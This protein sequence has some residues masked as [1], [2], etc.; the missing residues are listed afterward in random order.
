MTKDAFIS[1]GRRESLGFVGR[2]YQSLKLRGYEIWF[3]KVNIPDGDDY[4]KRISHGI[5]SAHN[6][7]LILAPRCLTSP[8]CLIELEYARKLGKRVIPIDQNVIFDTKDAPLS[9]QERSALVQFYEANGMEVLPIFSK[10]DVLNRS[11]ELLGKTDWVH[12]RQQLSEDDINQLYNWQLTYENR[13][14]RHEELEFTKNTE[15]QIPIFGKDIDN[16]EE[17]FERILKV[18]ESQKEYIYLHTE[19]IQKAL[20]WEANRRQTNLL[21]VGKQRQKAQNWLTQNFVSPNQ[22]PCLP[23]VLHSEFITESKKNADNLMSEVFLCFAP[24]ENKETQ[25]IRKGL[26]KAGITVILPNNSIQRENQK[27]FDTSNYT[28]EIKEQIAHADNFVFVLSNSSAKNSDCLR[29][30]RFALTFHKRIIVVLAKEVN[31]KELPEALRSLS[32]Y[33]DLTDNRTED[34]FTN[35]LD[36]EKDLSELICIIEDNY[37]YY[38]NHKRYLAQ[39]LKWKEQHQNDA[40][41]LRGHNLEKAQTWLHQGQ[42][43]RNSANSTKLNTPTKLHKKFIEESITKIGTLSSEVFISYSRTDGDFARW[44]NEELQLNGR[45]TWFDQECIP[46]GSDFGL[47]IKNGIETSDNFLFILSPASISS[48]YCK[49]EVLHALSMGKR[50]ILVRFQAVEKMP[51]YFPSHIQWIDFSKND[52]QADNGQQ[53]RELLRTLNTDREHTQKHSK[54]QQ[55][56]L[57]WNT[58]EKNYA[59]LLIGNELAIAENWLEE[60]QKHNKIPTSTSIQKDFI[61]ESIKS[62]NTQKRKQEKTILRLRVFLTLAVIALLAACGLGLWVHSLNMQN[63]IQFLELKVAQDSL[64]Q[65]TEKEKALKFQ[66]YFQTANY[67]KSSTKYE[68][69]IKNYTIA[70][71]FADSSQT[72]KV[73]QAIQQIETIIPK[74]E[75]FFKLVEKGE[76]AFKIKNFVEAYNYYK[77]ADSVGYNS[78]LVKTHLEVLEEY[79]KLEI[80]KMKQQTIHLLEKNKEKQAYSTITKALLFA[81]S[82]TSL[83]SL[84]KRV[85][86]QMLGTENN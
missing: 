27:G 55:K 6:F 63:Q 48:P 33:I 39:A 42:L 60:C 16:F 80:N 86:R 11:H 75:T 59:F 47:E 70:L 30:L 67:Q 28:E 37:D 14:Q 66:N 77:Q 61:F 26:I 4:S 7:I 54:Y 19:I 10:K 20:L 78:H 69:A 9:Y 41:L 22:P 83:L 49:D 53:F 58:N 43:Q 44:L 23:S 65:T 36:F 68:E 62:A 38:R 24:Q 1:Y 35:N 74:K 45:T 18:I 17:G 72:I 79:V 13:W 31:K 46:A 52:L 32:S 5:E 29:E 64:I 84:E 85:M 3:D 12:T 21:L 2:L 57:E 51:D 34:N 76:N 40:I 73:N 81:P 25:K 82:D 15:N 71:N 56:A 50:I 8:Y